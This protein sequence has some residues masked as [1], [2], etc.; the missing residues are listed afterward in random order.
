[1]FTML[2][3]SPIAALMYTVEPDYHGNLPVLQCP[4]FSKVFTMQVSGGAPTT[5]NSGTGGKMGSSIEGGG[6][7]GTLQFRL[8]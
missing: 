1:M 8:V 5:G 2:N 4:I 6:P 3:G 7:S